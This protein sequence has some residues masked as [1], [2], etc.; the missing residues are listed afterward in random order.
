MMSMP[1]D[2]AGDRLKIRPTSSNVTGD[3]VSSTEPPWERNDKSLSID[4][5]NER[6]VSLTESRSL[7]ILRKCGA[8]TPVLSIS[9]GDV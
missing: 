4:T 1:E 9:S 3:S 8:E 2:L 7:T 5:D 6:N